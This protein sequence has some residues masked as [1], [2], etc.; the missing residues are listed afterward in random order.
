MFFGRSL[1]SGESMIAR[2]RQKELLAEADRVGALVTSKPSTARPK[3]PIKY[4]DGENVL[5]RLWQPPAG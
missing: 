2:A 4:R 3:R 5:V 1:P